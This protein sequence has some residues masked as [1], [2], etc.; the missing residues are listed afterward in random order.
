MKIKKSLLLSALALSSLTA[1]H[2]QS[3]LSAWNFDNLSLGTSS[4][5]QPSTGFGSAS[6]L[7][8]GGSSSPTVVSQVGSS[9][10]GAQAWSVGKTG[11]TVGWSTNSQPGMQGA[12]FSASTLGYYQIQASFDIYVNTNSEAAVLVQYSQDGISWQNANITSAGTAGV[13]AT[14]TTG[15]GIVTGVS[16]LVLTNS[17]SAGWD[18]GVTVNLTGLQGV[19]N[20]PTFAIRIVNAGTGTN[21]L[22]TTGSIYNSANGGD[23]TLDNVAVTGVSFDTVASWTFDNITA[24]KHI[25]NPIPAVS[26]NFAN[27]TCI[28]FG[29]PANPLISSTFT[30]NNSTNDADVTANGVPYSSTGAAGQN[31]WRLR[32]QPGNGW[33]STQPI[34]SQGAEIDVSTVNYNNIIVTFD[35]YFTTQGEARM[36]VLYTTNGWAT[37]SVAPMAC[38]SYP[39][40]IQTNTPAFSTESEGYSPD[41]VNGVYFDQ[42]IGALFFNYFSVDFT[43]VPYVANNPNFGFRIVNAAQNGQCV[44]FLHQAYNNNSGNTRVD[45]IAVSGQFNGQTAPFVTNALAATVDA[46]FTNT[47]AESVGANNVGWHTNINAIFVNGVKLTN[48]AYTISASNIVFNPAPP[49]TNP[50]VLDTAGFDFIVISATNYTSAKYFQFVGTGVAKKLTYTQPSGP[51]ASGGTLLVNP[52][53]TVTD[54]Y[55]NGTTNPYN[56]MSITAVVSNSPATWTLGGSTVQTIL[57]GSCTF[58]DLTATLVGSTAISNAAITFMVS[59]YTNA[60]THGATTNI[61]STAFTIGPPPSQ[62]TQGNLAVLQVDTAANN[63]TFSIVEIRPSAAGQ[64]QPLNINPISATGTNAM[65]MT[66][67]GGAGHL[68]LSDDGTFLVFGIFDDGSS[69]TPDETFNLNRGVGTMNYTNLVTKAAKYVSE[70]LGGSAVRAACSPDSVDF[71]IDDKGGLY[72]A[73]PGGAPGV[74]VYE[75][76][77]YCVRSF[78]GSAWSLTQKVVAHVSSPVVFQFNNGFVGALDYFDSGNDGPYNTASST[79]P[80]DPLVVDFY[81]ISTNGS[82]DPVSFGILYTVDNNGGTNA[83]STVINKFVRNINDDSWAAIGSW[84]NADNAN[85]LFATTNGAGGVYLYYANGSGAANSIVRVTDASVTG[86]LNIVTTNTIYTAPA[87]ATAIGVTFVP[88]PSAGTATLS[89]PPILVA[90]KFAPTNSTFAVTNVPDDSLWRGA[91]T[92]I[93]V[94][95]SALA[96]AAY[97]VTQSGKIVFDPSQSALLQTPGSKAIVISATGY[98]TNY[99]TQLVVGA[100]AQLAITT[101]PKAP[102]FDGGV[103]ANQ[104]AIQVQDAFGNLVASS[105]TITAQVGAGAWVVGGNT[106]KTAANGAATFSGV[107]AFANSAISGASIT[108]TSP[109]LT[110]VTSSTFNIPAPITESLKSTVLVGGKLAFTFTNFTGLSFSVLGTNQ[111]G[112]PASTWPLLGTAVEG[113]AGTYRFTNSLPAT[114]AATFYILRQP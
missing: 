6:V 57:N 100:A 29:T 76:N 67:G 89:P 97:N 3:T 44:N 77:N 30:P 40:F 24:A 109:G 52:V 56:N 78:G 92:G 106:N 91:I 75:E 42:T 70:S 112:A 93:T 65:R 9:T 96:P 104:P 21:C 20:D 51:A 103:L 22:D 37:T 98:S 32:G 10:G 82:S 85:S 59:G 114:N 110:P 31:V 71:L 47:F 58:T 90:Q 38:S 55:G 105:A 68:A 17:T 14:N 16:Y 87:G 54:Q 95:G 88:L 69:A 73:E 74:N 63:S 72:V 101:Q 7:G 60:S 79:P 15:A 111:L 48:T 108:F 1:A 18:N 113:P 39:T 83:S 45:N 13:L 80:T 102:L 35:M 5:P 25:N 46:P 26:N 99:I 84:T 27:A 36:C 4:A 107:T 64:T 86:P 61:F 43:G 19:A 28:G 53:F 62:F 94:N 49:N 50:F 11:A 2:A 23:W 66:T 33:L 12:Q 8:F 81:M 34:G 41:I